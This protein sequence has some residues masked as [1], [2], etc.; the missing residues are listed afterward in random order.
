MDPGGSDLHV[1]V[2]TRRNPRL[3]GKLV[4]FVDLRLRLDHPGSPLK[5]N[6]PGF[7]VDDLLN[8]EGNLLIDGQFGE[9]CSGI[10]PQQQPLVVGDE[11]KW[12]DVRF[13]Q[14]AD[15]Q[16]TM[17]VTFQDLP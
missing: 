4:R 16:A 5:D 7:G 1:G 10:R 17:L 13:T 11:I 3:Q 12:V 15:S 9:L 14:D 2:F 6:T 8:F